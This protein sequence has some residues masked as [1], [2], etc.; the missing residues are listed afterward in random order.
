MLME[1]GWGRN[2]VTAAR[3]SPRLRVC[4]CGWV[5]VFMQAG[6]GRADAS[7]RL[8][9]FRRVRPSDVASPIRASGG[10]G[11]ADNARPLQALALPP[12]TRPRPSP[13]SWHPRQPWRQ[14]AAQ[15]SPYGPSTTLSRGGY[16]HPARMGSL[17]SLTQVGAVWG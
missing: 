3:P 13:R 17:L 5:C 14:A 15:Q 9:A 2:T 8:L 12:L 11:L 1:V 16:I 4:L 6:K 10:W 7:C